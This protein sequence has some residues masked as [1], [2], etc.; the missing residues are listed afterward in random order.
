MFKFITSIPIFRRLFYAFL[1][2]AVIPGITIIILGVT[3]VNTLN[4]R[5]IAVQTSVKSVRA[6]MDAKIPLSN[7]FGVLNFAYHSQTQPNMPG[8]QEWGQDPLTQTRTLENTFDRDIKQ[9]QQEYQ[10]TTSPQMSVIRNILLS[11]DPASS[12][13]ALQQNALNVVMEKLWPDYKKIQ[14]QTLDSIQTPDLLGQVP[15]LLQQAQSKYGPLVSGWNKVEQ[16]AEDMGNNI[17]QVGPS[18]I[19]PIIIA[20]IAS[21]LG[22]IMVVVVIG[23]AMNLTITR[24]LRHLATLT[25]RIAKG[26]TSARAKLLNQD[27]ISM[28]A[29]SMNNMLDN[30]VRLIQETQSQRDVLQGQVEKLVREVSGVG[31]GDL[32]VQAEVTADALGVLADSFNYMVG[33]LGSLVVRVKSVSHEVESSTT[34]IVKRMTQLV[35]AGDG[36]INQVTK[37][38]T[39]VEQ[40]A[41]ASRQVA[42]RSQV[43]YDVAYLARQNAQLGREALQQSIQGMG[44]IND[45]VQTTASKVQNLGERSREIN[46]IVD[47]IASIAHQTNRLALDAAIQAAMAGENGKAF[48]AVAADIRRL[49]ERAKDQTVMIGRIVRGVRDDIGAVAVSMQDTERETSVGTQ[50]TQEAGVALESIFSAVEQ[51]AKEIEGIHLVGTQQVQSSSAVVQIMQDLADSIQQ[52]SAGTREAS[53]N[54][55][56]L[57]HLVEQLRSSVEAFKLRENQEYLLLNSRK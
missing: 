32:R 47:V 31:E 1:L 38:T 8:M 35:E 3:F 48:G 19:N 23:Y 57:A 29:N 51:Q 56:R 52:S 40:M 39:E 17:V 50:L 7:L 11:D 25:K 9:Y 53:L 46:E 42:E 34:S 22:M 10:I 36:Q 45:N 20:T 43:L 16:L 55:E 33:E 21:F 28:V 49:A 54:M 5:G 27:E 26:E 30:I 13:P 18:Q 41:A 24:P 12:L 15:A 4:A 44:R 2:A 37:T 14:D 6:A